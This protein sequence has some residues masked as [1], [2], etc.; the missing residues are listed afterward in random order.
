MKFFAS[1]TNSGCESRMAE[2]DVIVYSGGS[3]PVSKISNK[4]IENSHK[5]QFLNCI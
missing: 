5:S 3:V 1:L 2:F 4:Q